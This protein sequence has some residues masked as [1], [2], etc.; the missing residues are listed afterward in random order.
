MLIQSEVGLVQQCCINAIHKCV[1]C[2]ANT[3]LVDVVVAVHSHHFW[4]W[5]I[6]RS[7]TF[8]EEESVYNGL[9]LNWFRL[10]TVRTGEGVVH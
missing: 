2:L 7:T 8:S 5:L 10:S 6:A 9:A 4:F 1:V 3:K